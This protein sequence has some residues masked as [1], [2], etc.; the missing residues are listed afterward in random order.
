MFSLIDTGHAVEQRLEELFWRGSAVAREVRRVD[1]PREAGE[2]ISMI[3][4]AAKRWTCVRSNITQLVDRLEADGLAKRV[5]DPND[6]RA[7]RAAVTPLGWN[8]RLRGEGNGES[9]ERASKTPGASIT[10]RCSVRL[11]S[12]NSDFF[13]QIYIYENTVENSFPFNNPGRPP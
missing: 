4:C 3:E 7:V 5:E 9:A 13:S 2:P 12:S 10:A 11:Q 1:A 8:A 6:R